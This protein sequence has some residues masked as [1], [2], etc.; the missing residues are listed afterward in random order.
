[1]RAILSI[2]QGTTSSRA[3]VYDEK[4]RPVFTAQ[5]EFPQIYPHDGWVEHD[6]Q[7]IWKSVHRTA[8]KAMNSC[9]GMVIE[10]IGITNQ[11][12]TCIIWDRKTG[13]PIY[14]AIVWQDRRTADICEALKEQG[15]EQTVRTKTGLL[16]DPYFSAS[17]I[18]W[19]LDH[20]T[21]ARARAEAG[22]LAFGT[23]DTYLIWQLTNGAVHATDATNASRTSLYNIM[24]GAWD[25]E[26]CAIFNVPLELLPTVKNSMDDYGLTDAAIL[27]EAIPIFGVAGDQ[28][29]ASIGQGCL[30]AGDIKSTYGTGCFVMLNTG[31]E[32]VRSNNRLLSTI[33][34]Q[35]DG[36]PTYALEGSI[37]VAGAAVGWLRDGLGIIEEAAQCD[38]MARD[39]DNNTGVYMVPAFTGLGAPHWAPKA[40]GA[41]YGLTRDTGPSHLARA[42]LESVCYQTYDLLTAMQK[43]IKDIAI[44]TLNVDGGMA[45][46][47]WTMQYLADMVQVEILR[48]TNMET[49]ALGAALLAGHATGLYPSLGQFSARATPDKVFTPRDENE[50]RTKVLH[51][52]DQ[53]VRRTLLE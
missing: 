28:Q 48:P 32:I 52:W 10:A 22:E 43:D 53:A 29:A 18:G 12:E 14:N 24:T 26:L 51:Q 39:L 2:D 38:A 45:I 6:P 8:R 44:T 31:D 19:I 20:I 34:V 7:A 49:T 37:F 47:D 17:K 40:R 9:D 41:I 35:I 46:S 13:E 27:G 16:L 33:A 50:A 21:G 23:I 1:M 42:A 4:A 25:M 36:K 30:A 5:Q 11:R 3:I 15:Y